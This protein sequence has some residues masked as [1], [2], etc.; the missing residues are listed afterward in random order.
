MTYD[1]N[2]Y[3]HQTGIIDTLKTMLDDRTPANRILYASNIAA[4]FHIPV[5]VVLNFIGEIYGF[6]D[7]LD[8]AILSIRIKTF[9]PK[10]INVR[11]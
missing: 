4:G 1:M 7:E 9:E 3:R 8:S 11:R 10:I 2:Q 5:L 6:T